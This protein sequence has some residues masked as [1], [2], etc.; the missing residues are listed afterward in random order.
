MNNDYDMKDM[1]QRVNLTSSK[2]LRNKDASYKNIR[3]RYYNW[4]VNNY[5]RKISTMEEKIV[6]YNN[7]RKNE[8]GN[9]EYYG[10][11]DYQAER[12]TNWRYQRKLKNL[13]SQLRYIE[14]RSNKPTV[15][16]KMFSKVLNKFKR[17]L[18]ITEE[19]K[20]EINGNA[21]I[22]NTEKSENK[23]ET[24]TDFKVNDNVDVENDKSIPEEKIEL[25]DDVISREF[26]KAVE[27][28]NKDIV[29][30]KIEQK[31]N[32]ADVPLLPDNNKKVKSDSVINEQPKENNSNIEKDTDKDK[33]ISAEEVKKDL[34]SN[35]SS[36]NYSTYTA[37]SGDI[38]VT[39]ERIPYVG[40]NYETKDEK[41]NRDDEIKQRLEDI[42]TAM[43]GIEADRYFAKSD[44]NYIEKQIEKIKNSTD[45]D[46]A[47]KK[48]KLQSI[49]KEQKEKEEQQQ[50]AIE[51][52]RIEKEN[53]EKRNLEAMVANIRNGITK[54][55]ELIDMLAEEDERVSSLEDEFNSSIGTR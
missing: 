15:A 55:N 7:L 22:K 29:N 41:N 14:Y 37:S 50:K 44:A 49:I 4:R 34:N 53:L 17:L 27:L 9:K 13:E 54:Q 43:H 24:P 20:E 52:K 21:S 25:S 42:N 6:D 48:E 5:K 11:V 39:P 32:N 26:G 38:V 30:N 45:L 35:N 10:W 3:S 28:N 19:Q 40:V 16:Y 23:S 33:I 1:E 8:E 36:E 47:Q 46:Y 18:A 12:F 51:Q 31:E 2:A